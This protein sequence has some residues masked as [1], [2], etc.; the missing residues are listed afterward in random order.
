MSNTVDMALLIY[1]TPR[2]KRIAAIVE[3]VSSTCNGCSLVLQNYTD[4]GKPH[5][6]LI[7][8]VSVKLIG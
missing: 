8:G 7:F 4:G 1:W 5:S 3:D 6:E 2:A